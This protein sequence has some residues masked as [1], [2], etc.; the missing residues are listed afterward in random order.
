MKQVLK[1]NFN[2]KFILKI[3]LVQKIGEK[4]YIKNGRFCKT[5]PK[6]FVGGSRTER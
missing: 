5:V 6:R 4:K 1:L 2:L 3:I